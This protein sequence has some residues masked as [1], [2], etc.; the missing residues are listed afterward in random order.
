MSQGAT[1]APAAT[2]QLKPVRLY[3]FT[4]PKHLAAIAQCGLTVGDVPTDL[5][6]GRGLIGVW[7]TESSE[8]TGHGLPGG[9]TDKKRFRL[10]VEFAYGAPLLHKWSEW[11]PRNVTAATIDSLH[12]AAADEAGSEPDAWRSWFIYLGVIPLERIVECA[13]LEAGEP[14]KDW[15]TAALAFASPDVPPV[16]PW[17]RAAWQR[18]MLKNVRKFVKE[19]RHAGI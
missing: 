5:E 7:F 8:P 12:R 3:H 16:P 18:H 10:A 11:A 9:R 2:E 14:L 13:D 6:R 17:R 15:H 1:I 4:S 19:R